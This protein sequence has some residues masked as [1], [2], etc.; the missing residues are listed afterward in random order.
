MTLSLAVWS[1]ASTLFA[2][3][4]SATGS[5]TAAS[6]PLVGIPV[7]EL[8]SYRVAC[9][10][11]LVVVSNIISV[12]AVGENTVVASA[13]VAVSVPS[14]SSPDFFVVASSLTVVGLSAGLV[15]PVVPNVVVSGL[16]LG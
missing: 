5:L 12:V 11:R 4:S 8:P 10:S 14:V 9:S 15:L 3:S 1:P 16:R 6:G 13:T 7:V 2:A